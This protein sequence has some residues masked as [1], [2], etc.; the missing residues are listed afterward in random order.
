MRIH[1]Y[2]LF[3][4]LISSSYA[5]E[6]L[7]PRAIQDN[8]GSSFGLPF[9]VSPNG[10]ISLLKNSFS[11]GFAFSPII[12]GGGA[13][14]SAQYVLPER[15]K[16]FSLSQ[17][18]VNNRWLEVHTREISAGLGLSTLVKSAFRLGLV[19]YKGA[20]QRL[21]KSSSS[22]T[23]SKLSVS[24][25]PKNLK[26]ISSWTVGDRGTFEQFGGVEIMGS[27][28]FSVLDVSGSLLL[29]NAFILEISRISEDEVSLALIEKSDRNRKLG[30]GITIADVSLHRI[31]GRTLGAEFVLDLTN[32]DHHD[33]YQSALKGDLAELQSNL[34]HSSQKTSWNGLVKTATIGI[35]LVAGKSV[36]TGRVEINEKNTDSVL[37]FHSK[38]SKGFILPYRDVHRMLYFSPRQMVLFWSAELKKVKGSLLEKRFLKFGRRIGVEGFDFQ[39]DPSLKIGSAMTQLGITLTQTEVAQMASINLKQL[40][41]NYLGRCEELKLNCRDRRRRTKILGELM[42]S[43]KKPWNEGREKLGI[44]LAKNPSL[45]NSVVKTLQL[46]KKGYFYLLS[47]TVQ[48]ME[49]MGTITTPE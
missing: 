38:K 22:G 35:P 45:I 2:L 6:V 27:A 33:L 23:L 42:S 30:A 25:L 11:D 14:R 20:K 18:N 19:P 36:R 5:Y 31:Q 9:F 46:K 47:D 15:M 26:Q 4:L 37:V 7:E 44:L 8:V 32:M 39:V 12:N 41:E 43:V 28:A 10:E 1:F 3:M 16:T 21:V 17:K 49:G 29:Q 24:L 34:P 13:F 40:D 48:S